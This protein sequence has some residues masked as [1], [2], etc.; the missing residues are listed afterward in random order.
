[1]LAVVL[2][3]LFLVI[4]FAY[5]SMVMLDRL[6]WR[7]INFCKKDDARERLGWRIRSIT[8]PFSVLYIVLPVLAVILLISSG[9]AG[10]CARFPDRDVVER[11]S[12]LHWNSPNGVQMIK[13]VGA[14]QSPLLI[15]DGDDSPHLIIKG[16]AIEIFSADGT[17]SRVC[18]QRPDK[19]K[20][21][22]F[23]DSGLNVKEGDEVYIGSMLLLVRTKNNQVE[24]TSDTV[25]ITK[26][27]ALNLAATGKFR[28][29]N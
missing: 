5:A 23:A 20:Y 22:G 8:S 6:A 7:W 2:F 17:L 12:V 25:L 21:C 19:E 18:V 27:F 10:L 15:S 16:S 26:E 4:G 29:V 14:R 24:R 1:M 13:V 3:I 9:I 11:G 28:I